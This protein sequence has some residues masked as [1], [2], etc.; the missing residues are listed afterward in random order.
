MYTPQQ[1]ATQH[2]RAGEVMFTGQMVM[3]PG[4]ANN[5]VLLK[6]FEQEFRAASRLDHLG[7]FVD[8]FG[9][10]VR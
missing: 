4:M 10:P 5:K 1:Q 3:P 6:R 8:G 9:S 7:S 2:P